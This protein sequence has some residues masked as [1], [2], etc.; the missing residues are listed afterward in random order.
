MWWNLFIVV[1]Y[2]Y[3]NLLILIFYSCY[4]KNKTNI[5]IIGEVY[6]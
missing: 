5:N 6:F 3:N 4:S 2:L 1:I